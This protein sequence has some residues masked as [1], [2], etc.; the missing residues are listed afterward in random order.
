ML[1]ICSTYGLHSRTYSTQ[2]P[3]NT[4]KFLVRTAIAKH[5]PGKWTRKIGFLV[6]SFWRKDSYT[7]YRKAMPQRTNLSLEDIE[8]IQS[9]RG[10]VSAEETKKRFGIGTGR[11]YKI[12]RAAENDK[13][14]ATENNLVLREHA[15]ED[16]NSVAET[17]TTTKGKTIED[18]YN[19]LQRIE[20]RTM[21]SNILQKENNLLQKEN[22]DVSVDILSL[23]DPNEED[24]VFDKIEEIQEEQEETLSNTQKIEKIVQ[25]CKTTKEY[26]Y[27]F[28][29]GFAVASIVYQKWKAKTI[30]QNTLEQDREIERNTLENVERDRREYLQRARYKIDRI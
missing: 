28:S 3:N 25:V 16:R 26:L 8:E 18:V 22:K 13:V 1:Y 24:N 2:M 14:Q 30:E 20:S 10:K 5:V 29:I 23:L 27:Y 6:F 15:V 4:S 21:E 17:T 11:L 12:W 19:L 9:L 7:K